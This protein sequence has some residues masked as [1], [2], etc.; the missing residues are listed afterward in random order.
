MIP[1]DSLCRRRFFRVCFFAVFVGDADHHAQGDHG[2]ADDLFD[3]DN[4][5]EDQSGPYEQQDIAEAPPQIGG[6]KRNALQNEL[7]ADCV[8]AQNLC[9][10]CE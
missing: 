1:L 2:Y 10:F 4:F 7:P 8:N 6:C 3:G 5:M 9:V